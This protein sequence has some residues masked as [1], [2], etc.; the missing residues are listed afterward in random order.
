MIPFDGIYFVWNEGIHSSIRSIGFYGDI[1]S[2]NLNGFAVLCSMQDTKVFP[3]L[4]YYVKRNL[5]IAVE[6]GI[7]EFELF[8]SLASTFPFNNELLFNRLITYR[9]A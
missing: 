8:Y 1:H 6:A 2:I 3:W 5:W 4:Y 7:P 9:F